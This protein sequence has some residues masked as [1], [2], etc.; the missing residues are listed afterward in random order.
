MIEGY[1]LKSNLFHVKIKETGKSAHEFNQLKL[2][3]VAKERI[4]DAKK[5][6]NEIAYGLGFK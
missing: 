3:D 4:F 5:S 1:L 2:I 6:V